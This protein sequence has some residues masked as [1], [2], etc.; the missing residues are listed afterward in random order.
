MKIQVLWGMRPHK[1][2]YFYQS[3]CYL[4]FQANPKSGILD[5]PENGG[6]TLFLNIVTNMQV[7]MSLLVEDWKLLKLFNFNIYI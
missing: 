2:F 7:Y 6:N 5:Y 1:Y 4:H 3:F